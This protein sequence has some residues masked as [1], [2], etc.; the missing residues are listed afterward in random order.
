MGTF[1]DKKNSVILSVEKI[2][3]FILSIIFLSVML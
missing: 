3:N 1:A 2:W